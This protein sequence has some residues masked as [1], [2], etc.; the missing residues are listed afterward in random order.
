MDTNE[1]LNMMSS[2]E[3]SSS[4]VH[5]A[6]KTLLYQKSAEKVDQITPTVAANQ[7]GKVEEPADAVES[8]PQEE[9]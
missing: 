8:E 4:E 7:F 1:L 2:D 5:D 9:E 6:I 3:T